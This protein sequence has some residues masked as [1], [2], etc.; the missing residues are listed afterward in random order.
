MVAIL[1]R[2]FSRS[3]TMFLGVDMPSVPVGDAD[4]PVLTAGVTPAM[5]AA[6]GAKDAEAGTFTV[7]TIA[8]TRLTARYLSPH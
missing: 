1:G 4:Y 5:V 3:A 6:G 7:T 8:P 2:V